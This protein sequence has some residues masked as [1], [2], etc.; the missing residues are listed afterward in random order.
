[1]N[2]SQ[3]DAAVRGFN[4]IR[5]GADFKEDVAVVVGNQ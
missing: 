1:M 4:N 3:N 2:I 5:G